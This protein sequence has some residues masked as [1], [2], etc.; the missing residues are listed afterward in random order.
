MEQC[1]ETGK[2]YEILKRHIPSDP[3][4]KAVWVKSPIKKKMD[5]EGK[6]DDD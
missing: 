2:L 4:R 5:D 1:L 6:E 3:E